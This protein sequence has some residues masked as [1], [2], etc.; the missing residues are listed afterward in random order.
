M[1]VLMRVEIWV[2]FGKT[3]KFLK[4]EKLPL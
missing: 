3:V 2:E 1:V 4:V